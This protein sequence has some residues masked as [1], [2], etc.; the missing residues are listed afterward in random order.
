MYVELE[1]WLRLS[2]AGLLLIPIVYAAHGLG[3]PRMLNGLPAHTTRDRQ[4]SVLRSKVRLLLD[5]V[6]RL[7]WLTFDLE[8]GVRNENA[9]KAEIALAERRLDEILDEIR[10]AAGRSSADFDVDEETESLRSGS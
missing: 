9:V 8:R 7:N 10:G 4:F 2:L 1:P 5:V 3:I 6:R